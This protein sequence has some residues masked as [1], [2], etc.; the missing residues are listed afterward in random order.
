MLHLGALLCE[1]HAPVAS[2]ASTLFRASLRIGFAANTHAT[3]KADD[4]AIKCAIK[5]AIKSDPK[6]VQTSVV[7]WTGN[8]RC[9][10]P[11]LDL[12]PG[13]LMLPL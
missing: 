1:P 13:R 11:W 2:S 4:V 8:L 12:R 3:S 7:L 6:G 10:D 5:C 9:C